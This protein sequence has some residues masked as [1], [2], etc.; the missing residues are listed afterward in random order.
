MKGTC[1]DVGGNRAERERFLSVRRDEIRRSADVIDSRRTHRACTRPT[2]AACA[3]TCDLGGIGAREED[4]RLTLRPPAGT[5]RPAV[6]A[7][8]SHRVDEPAVTYAH[9]RGNRGAPG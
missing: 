7:C 6:D 5:A 4:Y 2:P 9:A 1:A 8:R 3:E